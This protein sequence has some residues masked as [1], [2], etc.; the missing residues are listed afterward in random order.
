MDERK[1]ARLLLAREFFLA[2][3]YF[4]APATQANVELEF[5]GMP[6]KE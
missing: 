2:S 6:R 5:E 1:K 3:I 4:L